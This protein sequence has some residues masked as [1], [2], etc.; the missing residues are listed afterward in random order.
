MGS[1]GGRWDGEVDQVLDQGGFVDDEHV[2]GVAVAGVRY[3]GAAKIWLPL[4]SFN[5]N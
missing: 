5:E 3:L 4:S 2:G 1:G